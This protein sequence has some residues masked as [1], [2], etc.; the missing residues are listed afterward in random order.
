MKCECKDIVTINGDTLE[1]YFVIEE[2]EPDVIDKIY[3]SSESLGIYS[4]LPY[5]DYMAGYCLRLTEEVTS[6]FRPGFYYYDLTAELEGGSRLTLIH[7]GFLTI[8]KKRNCVP[9]EEEQ[10]G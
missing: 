5:A 2:V 10:N 4:E 1:V 6:D 3:F 9:S 7:N 8:L